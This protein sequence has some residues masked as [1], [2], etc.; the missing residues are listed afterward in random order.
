MDV[1]ELITR[2]RH[3]SRLTLRALAEKSG[4]SHSTLSAY[5]NGR[6]SPSLATLQ[7]I[8]DAAGY[9]LVVDVRRQPLELDPDKRGREI[10]ELLELG[11]L[12]PATHNPTLEAPVFARRR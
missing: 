9:D 6:K 12:F 4:T 11:Q 10:V 5:E 7:R 3:E 2:C 1:G 8:L